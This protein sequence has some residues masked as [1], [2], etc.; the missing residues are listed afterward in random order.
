MNLLINYCLFLQVVVDEVEDEEVVASDSL[1]K[2]HQS[3]S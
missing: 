3:K 1:I 2:V